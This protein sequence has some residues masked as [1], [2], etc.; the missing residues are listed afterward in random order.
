M[1]EAVAAAERDG[2]LISVVASRLSCAT[3][4]SARSWTAVLIRLAVT[5]ATALHSGRS[6]RSHWQKAPSSRASMPPHTPRN[7]SSLDWTSV[8][9]ICRT[10]LPSEDGEGILFVREICPLLPVLSVPVCPVLPELRVSA[11]PEELLEPI[12]VVV[13]RRGLELEIPINTVSPKELA[14]ELTARLDR[15]DDCCTNEFRQIGQRAPPCLYI[16]CSA[17]VLWNV[18]DGWHDRVRTMSV[19]TNAPQ[20]M[21]HAGRPPE[22]AAAAVFEVPQT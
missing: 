20:H 19:G 8:I 22:E 6:S 4:D 21:A 5:A 12:V 13:A 15:S 18:C 3:T 10:T 7:S 2:S 11:C 17:H 16:Q 1:V 9:I 14:D